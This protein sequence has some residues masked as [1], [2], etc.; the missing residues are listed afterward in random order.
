M[1]ARDL[2]RQRQAQATAL[3]ATA[4]QRQEHLLGQFLRH[5]AAV[6]DDLQ[7]QRQRMRHRRRCARRARRGC[8]G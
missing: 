6:V 8:A 2:L 1:F 4:D 7:P 3:G 5:A